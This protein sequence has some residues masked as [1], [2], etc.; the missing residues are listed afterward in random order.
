MLKKYGHMVKDWTREYIVTKY[1]DTAWPLNV[2]IYFMSWEEG[3]GLDG[4]GGGESILKI[5]AW[6]T[7]FAQAESPFETSYTPSE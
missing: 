6:S 7:L 2:F 4:W 3:G 1:Y 5:S